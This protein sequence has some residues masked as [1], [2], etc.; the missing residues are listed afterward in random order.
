MKAVYSS[1]TTKRGARAFTLIEA[2]ISMVTLVIVIGSVIM[3]NLFGLSMAVR[4]QIWLGASD[5]AAQ[6]QGTLT[7]DI[8][9]AVVMEVGTFANNT[10]TQTTQTNVQQSG[11]ALLIFTNDTGTYANGPWTLYYYNVATNAYGLN[12]NSLIRSNFYITGVGDCKEVS[13][14]P[15]TNDLTHPIFTEYDCTDTST[16]LSNSVGL[17][18]VGIYLS[19]TKLQ[20]PEV[21]IENGSVVDLYQIVTTVTPRALL[22]Q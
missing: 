21:V 5:D 11:N 16:P 13:A 15:I 14:N 1:L 6:A 17:A 19:F 3:C 2:M 18:P 7:G 22:T 20:D 4:Q 10:F 8:R 9:S 12:S